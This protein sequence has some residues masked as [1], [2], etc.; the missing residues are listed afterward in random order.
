MALTDLNFGDK[1]PAIGR[2]VGGPRDGEE[3]HNPSPVLVHTALET[4]KQTVYEREERDG[5]FVWVA[6]PGRLKLMKVEEVY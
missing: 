1:R 3:V 2:F 4:G 6:Q 5:E